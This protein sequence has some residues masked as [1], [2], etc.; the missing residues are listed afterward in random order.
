M[1]FQAS[2]NEIWRGTGHLC[3][4][5]GVTKH[6]WNHAGIHCLASYI[7]TLNEK[8]VI[9]QTHYHD[10]TATPS[11]TGPNKA[12]WIPYKIT[13]MSHLR[14]QVYEMSDFT[15]M[16]VSRKGVP[17]LWPRIHYYWPCCDHLLWLFTVSYN[18]IVKSGFLW[19]RSL[20]C[21]YEVVFEVLVYVD[22]KF[23]ECFM[24]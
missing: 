23:I 13:E 9:R 11:P 20:K 24:R 6:H 2:H 19:F 22:I 7:R 12:W 8:Q 14:P 21:W 15:T 17:D 10:N 5:L 4:R 16:G 3:S 1:I 18:R